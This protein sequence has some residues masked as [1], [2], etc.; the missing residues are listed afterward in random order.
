MKS[1]FLPRMNLT[2]KS[3]TLNNMEFEM[4]IGSESD[5]KNKC[6]LILRND[7]L[8]RHFDYERVIDGNIK[9]WHVKMYYKTP[10]LKKGQITQSDIEN[11]STVV[12]KEFF[13]FK[14]LY[15]RIKK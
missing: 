2:L 8:I 14:E 12:K 6:D 5:Y 7:D 11:A 4:L 10:L 3:K 1:L 13:T 15:N 9:K